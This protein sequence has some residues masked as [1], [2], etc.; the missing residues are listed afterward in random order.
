MRQP[1]GPG[2]RLATLTACVVAVGCTG[3]VSFGPKEETN[4][5]ANVDDS[6]I[7]HAPGETGDSGGGKDTAP[8]EDTNSDLVFD[9]TY[10]HT[11][12]LS[13][14]RAGL[15]S[16][17]ADPFTYVVADATIDGDEFTSIG[18]RIKGRLGSY[19]ALPG[20]SAL[21]L[22]FLQFGQERRL[23]GLEKIN[24]N[25]MVQDCAKVHEMAEIGRAHV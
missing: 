5:S 14:E 25:N 20:K 2:R 23:H 7:E 15:N 1:G 21:K 12:D 19:R 24:L 16:L 22:D 8:D 11:V 13:I 17:G 3:G 9:A 6:A 18:V 4:D 10:I